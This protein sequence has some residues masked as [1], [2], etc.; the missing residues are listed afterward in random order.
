MK[1]ILSGA[2]RPKT[3]RSERVGAL[4]IESIELSRANLWVLN[5]FFARKDSRWSPTNR[6]IGWIGGLQLG[7]K[8]SLE[9]WLRRSW[10]TEVGRKTELE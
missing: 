4:R 2:L 7:G 8:T 10:R 1:S 3:D 9:L 5:G 6:L